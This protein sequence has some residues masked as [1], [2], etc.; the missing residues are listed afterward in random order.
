[1]REDFYRQIY[2]QRSLLESRRITRVNPKNTWPP[3]DLAI[4]QSAGN[5]RLSVVSG[6]RN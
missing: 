6:V 2:R 1:M 3:K 4:H 5:Y